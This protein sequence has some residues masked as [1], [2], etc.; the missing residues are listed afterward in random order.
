MVRLVESMYYPHDERVVLAQSYFGCP[1]AA[2][3]TDCSRAAVESNGHRGM[4]NADPIAPPPAF[5]NEPHNRRMR[6]ILAICAATSGARIA[7][8][9]GWEMQ[10]IRQRCS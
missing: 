9:H 7:N 5:V 8:H 1:T 3:M 4:L 10:W 6:C 2:R